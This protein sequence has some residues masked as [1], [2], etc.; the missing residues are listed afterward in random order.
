MKKTIMPLVAGLTLLIVFSAWYGPM[1]VKAG[2]PDKMNF[3]GRLT[4]NQGRPVADGQYSLTFQ[5]FGSSGG[6]DAKWV[7]ETQNVNVSRGL[8]SA[9]LGK[10]VSGL[11]AAFQNNDALFLQVKVGSEIL[12]PRLEVASPGYAFRSSATDALPRG[13]II[14]WS[15]SVAQIPSG[16][17]LCDGKNGT[18][19]LRG[20]FIVG[21]DAADSDYAAI[22][23]TGG[24]KK[25]T[26]TKEELPPHGHTAV[27]DYQQP[28]HTVSWPSGPDGAHT[29]KV[30]DTYRDKNVSEAWNIGAG[31]KPSGATGWKPSV[32][33]SGSGHTHNIAVSETAHSHNITVNPTG[34]G[35]AFE[36][37]PSYYVVAFIMKL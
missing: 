14:M 17:A 24:E 12:S 21:Y 32:T 11:E 33:S 19:D 10:S 8:F 31:N 3:Q 22:G 35:N 18:P 9:L 15:G 34:G 36:N 29:H 7:P 1:E 20:R 23:S 27:A 37:R 28:L 25:H 16:W 6:S 13:T 5:L 4:D 26:L 30:E 2:V